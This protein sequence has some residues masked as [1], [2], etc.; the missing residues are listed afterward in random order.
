MAKI[1][2]DPVYITIPLRPIT[3]KNSQRW[4]KLKGSGLWKLV[5]SEAYLLYEK[6]CKPFIRCKGLLITGPVN[7][8]TLFYIDADR[9]CDLSNYI[10]AIADILVHYHVLEDD[11][12]W[13]VTGWDGS[14]VYVDREN[15]RTEITIEP[16]PHEEAE[17]LELTGVGDF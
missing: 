13:I 17:Q 5:P 7:I 3:K 16:L 12:R 4:V 14:R 9:K 10:E 15:P 6:N 11:N 1:I 8:K 2:K